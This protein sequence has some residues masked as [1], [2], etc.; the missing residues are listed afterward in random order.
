MRPCQ[1]RH[2][3]LC[4]SEAG[5]LYASALAFTDRLQNRVAKVHDESAGSEHWQQ[6]GM[7]IYRCK[8]ISVLP[9]ASG[10]QECWIMLSFYT[11][12]LR[13]CAFLVLE[14][15]DALAD[16]AGHVLRIP[17]PLSH[18]YGH[19]MAFKL[20]RLHHGPWEISEAKY[21]DLN[22]T[23]ICVQKLFSLASFVFS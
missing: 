15:G 10:G 23:E 22:L 9:F 2:L 4:A 1:E 20:L 3:G 13:L 5:D 8:A 19:A 7:G 11:G 18:T 14:I 16:V 17:V 6:A 21:T 12:K